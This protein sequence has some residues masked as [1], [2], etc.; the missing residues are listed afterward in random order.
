MELNVKIRPETQKD[1]PRFGFQ[2]ASKWKI[3]APFDVP[4]DAFL[5][6]QLVPNELEDK[7]GMV[8]YPEEFEVE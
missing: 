8:E 2:P 7:S 3:S 1:Y 6:L 4:D 5:A